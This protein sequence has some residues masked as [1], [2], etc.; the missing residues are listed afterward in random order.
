M[1]GPKDYQGVV[2]FAF[3][4]FGIILNALRAT[5]KPLLCMTDF[6]LGPHHLPAF[7]VCLLVVTIGVKD[8]WGS[9]HEFLRMIVVAQGRCSV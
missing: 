8:R 7:G 3:G 2:P 6:L 9:N 1:A 4:L 5:C